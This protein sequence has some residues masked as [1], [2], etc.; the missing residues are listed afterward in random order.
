MRKSD[1]VAWWTFGIGVVAVLGGVQLIGMMTD[2]PPPEPPPPGT[3]DLFCPRA[4]AGKARNDT[5]FRESAEPY[6]GKGPH[7]VRVL[8]VGANTGE[9]AGELPRRWTASDET[10]DTDARPKPQLVAC[11]YQVLSGTRESRVCAYVPDF[12]ARLNL[13][14]SDTTRP[15]DTTKISLVKA[16]YVFAIYEAK[17]AKPLGSVKVPGDDA[18]PGKVE[19]DDRA[20]IGQSPDAAKL[21]KALSP[22]AERTVD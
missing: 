3:E 21:R 12:I 6:R 20:Y 16:A 15:A 14:L 10:S 2:P 9:G 18:C 13:Q 4:P 11:G 1:R 19:L 22:Y 8:F 5:Y 7:A 17:T